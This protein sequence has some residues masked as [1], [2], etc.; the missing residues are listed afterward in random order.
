[1][2][3]INLIPEDQR[4]G[5]GQRGKGGYL[6]YVLIG[7]LV[8][9]LLGV[10]L[11]VTANNDISNSKAEIAEL[12][13]ENAAAEKKAGELSA[14]VQLREVHDQRVA[15]V[16][17][18]AD[19]RFDWERVMRELSLI[20]PSD[21]WL[22]NLT[23]T[24]K[25]EVAVSDAQSIPLRTSAPGPALEIVGCADGQDAV[26]GFVSDL[27]DIDGV[28]R[29]AMQFSKLG[30]SEGSSAGEASTDSA[31]SS[32]GCEKR[33]FIAE[34]QIVA[35]FDAAPIPITGTEGTE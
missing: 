11:V 26:A 10:T 14:Y 24:V 4:R 25:P 28:T 30:D 2:R 6:A 20:L 1:M 31:G 32:E 35:A 7:G 12:E 13:T 23:G 22:T 33:H 18:L 17:A 5:P 19:S 9:L 34:F 21:V 8:A 29:V 16:T 15:T 3:P 27:K